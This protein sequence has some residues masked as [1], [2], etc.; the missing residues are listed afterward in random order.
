MVLGKGV[1]PSLDDLRAL[2][3]LAKLPNATIA[4]SIEEIQE[5]VAQWPHLARE[6]GVFAETRDTIHAVLEKN[7]L[8]G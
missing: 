8:S 2:G 4:Q 1:D 3:A 5:A 6:Y 7:L